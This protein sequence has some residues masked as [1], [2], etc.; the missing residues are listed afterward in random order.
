MRARSNEPE[1]RRPELL[2]AWADGELAEPARKEVE[3][4]LAADAAARAEAEGQ[5]QVRQW[6]QETPP[7]EP[8]A[9][10]WAAAEAAIRARLGAVPPAAAAP[11]GQAGG[12]LG[13]AVLAASVLLA[14]VL[15]RPSR[16]EPTASDPGEPFPVLAAHEVEII[17]IDDG[18][19]VALVVGEPPV[20][21]PLELASAGDITIQ[22]PLDDPRLDHRTSPPMLWAPLEDD[23]NRR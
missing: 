2:A 22:H 7:P 19:T 6:C 14:V 23:P 13:V 10:A 20:R 5:R 21:H 9:A 18:D 15:F 1:R 8:S 16:P 3:A 12:R 11:R 4:W 17:S